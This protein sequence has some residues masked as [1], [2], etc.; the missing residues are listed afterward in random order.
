MFG[1]WT[2]ADGQDAP[3]F[4]G[5][6]SQS[7]STA[8]YY[9]YGAGDP[10]A[11]VDANSEVVG[12]VLVAPQFMAGFDRGV[13][14]VPPPSNAFNQAQAVLDGGFSLS[15]NPPTDAQL[16]SILRDAIDLTKALPDPKTPASTT[17][18]LSPGIYI[19]TDGE[20]FTGSGIYVM[21]NADKILLS[22]DPSGNRQTIKITQGGSTVT[23]VV[24]V[25]AGTTTIDTGS[26]T[27]TLRGI[28]Q[29]RTSQTNRP[30]A[31]LYVYGDVKALAGPGRDATGQPLPAIDSSFALTVTAAA[32]L[33]GDGHQV[34]GGNVTIAGDLTYE[35]PVVDSVGNPINPKAQNVLGIYAS[36]G[37]IEVPVDGRAP[38]NL[39]VNASL[40]AFE[41]KD[42]QGTP[43]VS[44][45]GGP[46]G[47]RV[48]S[49]LSNW[50]EV[51]NRGR[52]TL[53]GGMQS[54]TYD[55]FAVYDGSIHGY[56]YQGLWD[57]RY[58]TTQFSPPFYPGYV[59]NMGAP[60]DTPVISILSNKPTVLS[61]KRIYYGTLPPGSA[62]TGR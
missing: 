60:T 56:S 61:Y 57:P 7:Y 29:D 34:A 6:V 51:G 48:R 33:T 43:V 12:G 22:A 27:R 25:D 47:G 38:M 8:S 23:V 39:Q 18:D 15:A 50:S 59:V 45:S 37:N 62:G 28:P 16:H 55:N 24:D 54:T 5:H 26:G 32:Y 9:R 10:P 20:I 41:M 3:V 36:G 17:P 14:A 30:G 2:G 19:P 11:P 4:R 49:D 1:F 35:T 52:F 31:S 13:P 46:I 21:G 40:A 53:V 42:A 44:T 58:D